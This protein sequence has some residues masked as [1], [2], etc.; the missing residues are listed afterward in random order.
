MGRTASCRI[1][2]WEVGSQAVQVDDVADLAG[3]SQ[4]RRLELRVYRLGSCNTKHCGWAAVE[5]TEGRLLYRVKH[6]KNQMA[7]SEDLILRGFLNFFFRLST[8][9][10]LAVVAPVPAGLELT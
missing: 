4:Q 10:T 6:Q 9:T 2:N 5:G 1:S 8:L 7:G 3:E